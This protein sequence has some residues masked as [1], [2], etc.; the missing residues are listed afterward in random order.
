MFKY[1][2]YIGIFLWAVWQT[3]GYILIA[4]LLLFAGGC[5]P[6]AEANWLDDVY[7][8][9][10]EVQISAEDKVILIEKSSDYADSHQHLVFLISPSY[11]GNA[12]RA[13]SPYPEEPY[14]CYT[15]ADD[16]YECD[17]EVDTHRGMGLYKSYLWDDEACQWRY[18]FDYWND[19]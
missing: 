17:W 11:C 18:Q 1:L 13:T 10:P 12:A 9:C 19:V 3:K 14:I 15:F 4:L 16:T 6:T 7:G 8:P 5:I 2:M